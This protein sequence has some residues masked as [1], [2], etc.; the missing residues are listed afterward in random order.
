MTNEK[1]EINLPLMQILDRDLKLRW[2]NNSLYYT[3]DKV[4]TGDT[5]WNYAGE[6]NNNNIVDPELVN[7]IQELEN[8]YVLSDKLREGI[9]YLLRKELETQQIM[10]SENGTRVDNFIQSLKDMNN[11]NDRNKTKE[12]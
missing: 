3:F 11:N 7:L 2:R 12:I 8:P 9:L 10:I 4:I 6:Y 5:Q 1:E